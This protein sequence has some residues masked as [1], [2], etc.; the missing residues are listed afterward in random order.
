MSIFLETDQLTLNEPQLSDFDNLFKLQTDE[1]VMKYIG[2]G[3][4]NRQEVIDFMEKSIQHFQKHGFGFCTVFE[5]ESKEFV[6]QAGLFYL[7]YD[8]T[9]PDIE[10][11]YRLARKFWGKGYATV[12][13][14]ALIAWGFQNISVQKLVAV[15]HLDNTPSS[16]VLEKSGIVF[17]G[18]SQYYNQKVKYYEINKSDW[19]TLK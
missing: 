10:V 11:G 18:H 9:Q 13:T 3:I 17:C 14:K 1:Q 16:R 7:V 2:D 6:G 8:D 4:R 12:L 15:T 19:L 5:K